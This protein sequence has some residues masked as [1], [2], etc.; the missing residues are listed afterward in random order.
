MSDQAQAPL[1]G[2]K[3]LEL[4]TM[5]S[6]PYCARL[7]ADLGADV[8][9]VESPLGD[10]TREVPPRFEG[11]GATFRLLNRN[12]RSVVLDLKD[13][14]DAATFARLAAETDV[15]IENLKPGALERLGFSE[16][17]LKAGNDALV[18][19]SISGFGQS[20]PWADRPAYDIVAQAMSGLMAVTGSPETGPARVGIS[21]GDVLP[22]VLGAFAVVSALLRRERT[23]RGARIDLAM[24]D[25]LMTGLESVGMRA[26]HDSAPIVP[27]GTDH[28][29]S[30]PY[31]MFSARDGQLVIAVVTNALF[32]RLAEA[33]ERPD[34]LGDPRFASD[35][36]RGVHRSELR[37]EIEAA[38][39]TVP[40]EDALERLTAAGVACAPVLDPREALTG[41]Y[42]RARGVTAREA[43]GFTTL[44]LGFQI[45]DFQPPMHLAPGHGE[46]NAQAF[47]TEGEH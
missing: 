38:L 7:L 36:T 8:I 11:T 33:L 31:G 45:D 35:E 17:T 34:W 3:V 41:A 1:R 25:A 15:L 2:Y 6:A 44:G 24:V 10:H 9:K 14:E 12:K 21:I 47:F 20:G 23:D 4:G 32:A 30:A 5:I 29:L 43:D 13:P 37:K 16:Q 26:L 22:G 46:H 19:L 27:T 28:A 42:A 40:V 18:F 39:E